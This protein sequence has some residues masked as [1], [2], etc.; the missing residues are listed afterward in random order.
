M[1]CALPARSMLPQRRMYLPAFD[2][3]QQRGPVTPSVTH[4]PHARLTGLGVELRWMQ[5]AEVVVAAPVLR[6]GKDHCIP[7]ENT[8]RSSVIAQEWRTPKSSRDTLPGQRSF[9]WQ[10]QAFN[11]PD[12]PHQP[13]P[14]RQPRQPR[15][16][17]AGFLTISSGMRCDWWYRNRT[18]SRPQL[19]RWA[20]ARRACATGITS[21]LRHVRPAPTTP[22]Q[23]LFFNLGGPR[24]LATTGSLSLEQYHSSTLAGRCA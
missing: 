17:V 22:I 20:S 8:G 18:A 16:L 15:L 7:T 2:P 3:R 10:N 1:G 11:G 21:S 4:R 23:A 12:R 24:L 19:R 6:Q 14:P 9:S 5:G 13:H